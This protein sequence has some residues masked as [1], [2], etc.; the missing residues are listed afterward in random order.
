MIILR[1]CQ[2]IAGSGTGGAHGRSDELNSQGMRCDA[3]RRRRTRT[4]SSSSSL[5]RSFPTKVA[6]VTW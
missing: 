4:P 6:T 3:L 1:S 5:A 2:V